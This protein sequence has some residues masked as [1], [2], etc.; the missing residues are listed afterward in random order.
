M[1]AVVVALQVQVQAK[2]L[3]D[4]CTQTDTSYGSLFA[5]F[6]GTAWWWLRVGMQ[7]SVL[8]ERGSPMQ[9]LPIDA[10][11]LVGAYAPFQSL[12]AAI[13]AT[14]STTDSRPYERWTQDSFQGS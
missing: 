8:I 3:A 14:E 1:P 4:R 10:P 6:V 7:Q 11:W 2:K 12:L 9:L 13:R 5:L